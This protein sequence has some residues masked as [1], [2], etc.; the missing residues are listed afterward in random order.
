MNTV[1]HLKVTIDKVVY[2]SLGKSLMVVMILKK[3][4]FIHSDP[5]MSE[6]QAN[7]QKACT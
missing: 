1:N 2:Y 5:I 6:I 3:Q 7:E 4:Q